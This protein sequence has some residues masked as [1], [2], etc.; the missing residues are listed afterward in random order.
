MNKLFRVGCLTLIG[1]W[2]G[3]GGGSPT[4]SPET[5]APHGGTLIRLP[6]GQGMVEVVKKASPSKSQPV[7]AEVSFY[8]LKD[9]NT[10]YSPA[11]SAGTLTTGKKTVNLKAEGDGLVTPNGPPLFPKGEPDGTL[12]V[13]LDGKNVKIPLG[14]RE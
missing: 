12:A 7:T 10:P 14:V 8:F 4:S 13:D 11:P 5:T 9:A 2:S 1:V 3:C 6:G